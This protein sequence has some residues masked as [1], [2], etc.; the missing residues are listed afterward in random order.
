LLEEG[1]REGEGTR[2]RTRG[3]RKGGAGEW[4][5]RFKEE[6]EARWGR[7]GG[8]FKEEGEVGMEAGV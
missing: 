6:G 1:V 8:K 7:R 4:R 5:E 3:E 2:A